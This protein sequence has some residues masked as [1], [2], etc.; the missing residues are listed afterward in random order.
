MRKIALTFLFCLASSIAN[1]EKFELRKV[2]I[3]E[4]AEVVFDTLAKDFKETPLWVGKSD[5]NTHITLTVNKE[6]GTWT[7]IEYDAM[8]ACV[9][10]VGQKGSDPKVF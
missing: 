8:W 5:N 9:F 7:L 6:S 3:C 1:A 10:S 4:K 2:M